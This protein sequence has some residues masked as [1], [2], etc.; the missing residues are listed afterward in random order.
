M[1]ASQTESRR[2]ATRSANGVRRTPLLVRLT[3]EERAILEARAR[4][5]DVSL[6]RVLID[7]ALHSKDVQRLSKSDLDDAVL[8][9]KKL[10]R[11]VANIGGNLNQLSRHANST[12]EFPDDVAPIV[13]EARG[14]VTDIRAVVE[15]LRR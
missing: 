7:D 11:H 14:V 10:E 8:L 15:E 4:R 12:Q 13:D 2:R 3:A 6:A 5:Y 9:L 1:T